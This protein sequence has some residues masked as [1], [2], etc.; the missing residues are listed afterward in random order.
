MKIAIALYVEQTCGGR[1]E[2]GAV[3]LGVQSLTGIMNGPASFYAEATKSTE[4]P[5]EPQNG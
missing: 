5:R 2:M 1:V 4:P 3:K